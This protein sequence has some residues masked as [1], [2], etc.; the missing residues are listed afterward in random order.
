MRELMIV[1]F[2]NPPLRHHLY[3]LSIKTIKSCNEYAKYLSR[4]NLRGAKIF[5]GQSA[6]DY[7][8]L[9]F[10]RCLFAKEQCHKS[11]MPVAFRLH[12]NLSIPCELP[13]DVDKQ[14]RRDITVRKFSH[15]ISNAHLTPKDVFW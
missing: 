12:V 10:L 11:C 2:N 6:R 13:F 15:H 3:A 8:G 1:L 5:N 9:L 7:I 4:G 14:H